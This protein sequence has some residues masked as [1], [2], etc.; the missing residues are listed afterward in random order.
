MKRGEKEQMEGVSKD[1]L[2]A[3]FF[4]TL[5]MYQSSTGHIIIEYTWGTFSC[6]VQSHFFHLFSHEKDNFTASSFDKM[7]PLYIFKESR[8]HWLM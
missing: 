3:L 5:N 8:T 4:Y 7:L 6:E 2:Q 1:A